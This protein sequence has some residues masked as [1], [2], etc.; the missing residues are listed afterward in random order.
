MIQDLYKNLP[1]GTK[2]APNIVDAFAALWNDEGVKT[3]FRRAFEYQLNDS[4]P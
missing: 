3:C 4:A 2:L 1:T